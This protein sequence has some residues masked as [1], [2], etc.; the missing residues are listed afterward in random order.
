MRIAYTLNGLIGGFVGKNYQSTDEDSILILE[1]ISKLI[2]KY[3]TAYN[4]V[5]FFV[6]SW[7]T[8]F[9]L[10]FKEFLNPKKI[11]LE[12]QINFKIPQHLKNGNIQRVMAHKSRW[13][14][15][16]EVMKLVE[17]YEFENTF[18]YDLVVN[19]RFDIC[20]NKPIYFEVFDFNKFHIPFHLDAQNY[21]WPDSSPEILDHIFASNS[22]WMRNYSN[23]FD[24]LDEYTL[25]NQ[26]PQWNTISHH[27]LMVWHLNKLNI[28]SDDIVKKSFKSLHE[29]NPN[30]IG[31][32]KD[33][34]IDYDIF[35]YRQLDRKEVMSYE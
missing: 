17:E 25:P 32:S 22:N 30:I 2:N 9:E 16:K 5:D 12:S 20:W 31:G 21:G 28:L 24:H 18:E 4:N 11:K 26:C 15:Y 23:M 19:A 6:F 7:H 29:R 35:R 13:Y 33:L 27:F 1:Y 10:Y 8:N 3:I 34:N 14:G